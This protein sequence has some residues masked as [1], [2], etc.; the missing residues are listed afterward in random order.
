MVKVVGLGELATSNVKGDV[1]KTYS[2]ASCVGVTVYSKARRTAG[3]AHIV[4][5][6]PYREAETHERQA[7]YAISGVPLLINRMCE[8]YGCQTWE[9]AINLY[10]G[11][12]SVRL[13][14]VF[15][16]GQRNLTEIQ[17]LLK[18]MKLP[19]E[20]PDIGGNYS[21]TIEMDISTGEVKV[22]KQPLV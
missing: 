10:G 19:Y 7:Y 17:M 13:G 5:P 18:T 22:T 4:L 1:L 12:N 15:R 16:V 20:T 3:M 6:K 8:D 11:A 9:L 21:R 2:L 14:D